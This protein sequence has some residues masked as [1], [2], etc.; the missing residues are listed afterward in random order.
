MD[1]Y[2]QSFTALVEA[3]ERRGFDENTGFEGEFRTFAKNIEAQI[4]SQAGL[5][6]LNITLLQ[7]RRNEKDYLARGDQQYVDQIVVR[8]TVKNPDHGC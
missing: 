3:Y 6:S 4:S 2:E 5:K 1:T 8:F 7:I